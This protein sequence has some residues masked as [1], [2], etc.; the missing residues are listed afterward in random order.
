MA[1]RSD[2]LRSMMNKPVSKSKESEQMYGEY[3]PETTG[4][5][6]TE[7]GDLIDLL[8]AEKRSAF[9]QDLTE[10]FTKYDIKI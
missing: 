8:P 2:V 4:F 7:L 6:E 1:T 3:N 10:L 5:S 9:V